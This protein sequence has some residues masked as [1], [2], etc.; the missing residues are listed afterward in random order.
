MK[1]VPRPSDTARRSCRPAV[2]P[3]EVDDE[4]LVGSEVVD[5]MESPSRRVVVAFEVANP[6]VLVAPEGE[7]TPL[8]GWTGIWIAGAPAAPGDQ[9]RA[10]AGCVNETVRGEPGR[11]LVL[12]PLRGPSKKRSIRREKI[13]V[14]GR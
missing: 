2:P 3:R 11:E 7:K 10:A 14:A 13:E 1:C 4:E 8:R 9:I 12:A 6:R 5:R